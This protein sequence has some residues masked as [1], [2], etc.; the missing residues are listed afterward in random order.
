MSRVWVVANPN[1]A[2]GR[3]E[4]VLPRLR[5]A[6]DA[7][8]IGYVF[9]ETNGPGHARVIAREAVSAGVDRLLVVGGDGTIHEAVGGLLSDE[10]APD[11]GP[12]D[13]EPADSG[14]SEAATARIPSVAVL[15]VGTG[16][17][18]HR[19]V[20]AHAGIDDAVGA[21]KDG[22]ARPFEVGEVRWKGGS[23]RFV[24]LVGVGVDVEVLRR[25]AAFRKLPGV[26][27]YLAAFASAL[28]RYEPITLRVAVESPGSEPAGFESSVLLSAV[29]VGPSVG[30]GFLLSPNAV[31]DD[32]LL[33]LFLVERLGLLRILRYLP[34]I[35]RGS[36]ADRP[37]IWQ[38][39]GTRVDIEAVDGRGFA[40]ELDG[41]LVEASTP[42]LEIH[43]RPASLQVLELP[44][45]DA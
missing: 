41:E 28:R 11:A 19:M 21:L 36:T 22:A 23:E 10:R 44:D 26:F 4:R 24:N 14:R 13:A 20:R 42:Y 33:D 2:N 29:T 39:Q 17:D 35:L 16:N 5:E 12:A 40:F 8:G 38:L 43:V 31:P 9:R 1:A 32:G 18:F 37:G 25:R 15:P 27:Q 6:L 7:E 30:G 34:G 45:G 3:A